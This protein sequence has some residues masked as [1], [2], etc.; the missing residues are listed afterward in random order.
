MAR[1]E[2]DTSLRRLYMDGPAAVVA[3]GFVLS[4]GFGSTAAPTFTAGA[5]DARGECTITCGGT[6]QGAS[7]TCTITFLKPYTTAPQ[8]FTTRSGGDQPTINFSVTSSST[9]G[10]VLTFNGTASGT[11]AY[12]FR[13]LVIG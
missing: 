13:Y 12:K 5:N 9:T 6:G 7:P 10:C 11:E 2:D 4:S 3:G 1:F 8:V